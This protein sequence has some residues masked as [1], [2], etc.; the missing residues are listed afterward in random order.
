MGEVTRA[1]QAQLWRQEQTTHYSR[2]VPRWF[3]EPSLAKCWSGSQKR[4]F[5]RSEG[6]PASAHTNTC[7]NFWMK[8]ELWN[9]CCLAQ[10]KVLQ[11]IA[12]ALTCARLTALSKPDG[13]V[14]GTTGC[15]LRRLVARTLAK[16]FAEEFE[17]ECAPF[18]CALSGT[19]EKDAQGQ[20]HSPICVPL[21]LVG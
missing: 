4:Q 11:E 6:L 16:Q 21:K 2:D 8:S 19:L 15:S 14:R 17:R 12:E 9:C 1:R 18:Q 7:E 3:R 13:G 10:A 20:D 5:N